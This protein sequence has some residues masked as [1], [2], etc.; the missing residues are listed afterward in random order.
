MH[1]N[2]F[3]IIFAT[4]ALADAVDKLQSDATLLSLLTN[5]TWVIDAINSA[6]PTAWA[7]SFEYDAAFASSVLIAENAGTMPAWYSDLPESVVVFE[8][9]RLEA[10]QSYEATATQDWLTFS[11]S[12]TSASAT[13][14]TTSTASPISASSSS[15]STRSSVSTGGAPAVTGDVFLGFAG[16]AGILGLAMAL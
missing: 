7:S 1:Y 5:P 16:A 9:T 13:A 14:T 10:I 11:L 2:A 12:S 3:A 15:G 4:T 6:E 8:S